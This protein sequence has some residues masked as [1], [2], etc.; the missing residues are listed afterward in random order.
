MKLSCAIFSL[1]FAFSCFGQNQIGHRSFSFMI[2]MGPEQKSNHYR[3]EKSNLGRVVKSMD[4]CY[5]NFLL[6]LINETEDYSSLRVIPNYKN[7]EL[8]NRI[9]HYL[10]S[11]YLDF[12]QEKDFQ[13]QPRY[14]SDY[15]Y[16][17][18]EY[19]SLEY[20][21]YQVNC[22]FEQNDRHVNGIANL[23]DARQSEIIKYL[24]QL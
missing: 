9:D 13:I 12:I 22:R 21:S 18:S 14:I 8:S 19:H 24:N 17:T 1:A 10:R 11:V 3:V 2:E 23:V 16:E 5:L 15:H 20:R 7:L 6:S 4:L